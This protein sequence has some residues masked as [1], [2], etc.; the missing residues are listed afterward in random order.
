MRQKVSLT[1]LAGIERDRGGGTVG[2]KEISD[3]RYL[4]RAVREVSGLADNCPAL[5]SLTLTDL[6]P[7]SHN[8]CSM[9]TID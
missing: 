7:H 3:G 2:S 9:G 1:V 6:P 5:S 4:A 8:V